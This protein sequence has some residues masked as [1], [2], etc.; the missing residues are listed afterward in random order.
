M[1]ESA[2]PS[3]SM[4]ARNGYSNREKERERK[5]GRERGEREKRL[6]EI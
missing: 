6:N 1:K 3:Y 5:S 2:K 4:S